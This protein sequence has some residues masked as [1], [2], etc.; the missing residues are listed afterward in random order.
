M[1]RQPKVGGGKAVAGMQAR[2]GPDLRPCV[3]AL[4]ANCLV[5][6]CPVVDLFGFPKQRGRCDRGGPC[7]PSS[8]KLARL[9]SLGH[10]SSRLDKRST[11][12]RSRLSLPLRTLCFHRLRR[13]GL[14]Q[15]QEHLQLQ[16]A[17]SKT[18]T[19]FLGE[20]QN[21][22]TLKSHHFNSQAACGSSPAVFG[23]PSARVS[24][25]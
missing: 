8:W 25:M 10:G 3:G 22:G 21:C 14:G 6:P 23:Q 5:L 11:Q 16:F 19:K 18:L 12:L 15:L 7:S 2:F 9:E 17:V 13:C 1:Q 4:R 20:I 24:K